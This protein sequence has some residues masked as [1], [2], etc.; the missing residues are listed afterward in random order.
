MVCGSLKKSAPSIR[1][2]ISA[3]LS[4]ANFEVSSETV[5]RMPPNPPLRFSV[6]RNELQYPHLCPG[7]FYRGF[8]RAADAV[9]V[10]RNRNRGVGG[11]LEPRGRTQPVPKSNIP[12]FSRFIPRISS[13]RHCRQKKRMV[14]NSG[15]DV[16]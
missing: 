1:R 7:G 9:L 3:R 14:R 13:E 15:I 16:D 2:R 8:F 6:I 10:T 12:N 5:V 11:V 4:A